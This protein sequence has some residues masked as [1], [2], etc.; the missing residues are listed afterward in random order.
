LLKA[1]T[2]DVTVVN[3]PIGCI[4][5]T[6]LMWLGSGSLEPRFKMLGQRHRRGTLFRCDLIRVALF[7]DVNH[8]QLS[9]MQFHTL[10][11]RANIFNFVTGC[12]TELPHNN[13]VGCIPCTLRYC[14]IDGVG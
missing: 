6:Y 13:H 7:T 11:G 4:W 5:R 10:D 3:V 14:T 12:K 2:L 8:A 1:A 9:S